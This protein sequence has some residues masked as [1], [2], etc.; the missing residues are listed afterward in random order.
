MFTPRVC[1]CR[2]R[3]RQFI[4]AVL[5]V[6]AALVSAAAFAGGIVLLSPTRTTPWELVGAFALTVLGFTGCGCALAAFIS[7]LRS[8][9]CIDCMLEEQDGE[10]LVLV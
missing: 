4:E 2:L 5:C 1:C 9:V 3:L 10:R 6:I 7:T 8:G